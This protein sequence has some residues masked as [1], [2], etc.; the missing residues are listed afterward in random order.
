MTEDGR[1]RTIIENIHP[2]V[3]GGRFC[4]KHVAGRPLRV[5]AHI[6]CDGHDF[7][8]AE[9]S[10]RRSGS[11]HKGSAHT[12]AMEPGD[13]DLFTASFIPEQVGVW[14]FTITAWVDH[15]STMCHAIQ[16]KHAAGVDYSLDA[17]E[18]AEWCTKASAAVRGRSAA[19]GQARTVL[20]EAQG[21]FSACTTNHPSDEADRLVRDSKLK[22]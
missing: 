10:F 18:L 2:L 14:E 13:N 21:V 9:L 19:A 1:A 22:A 4:A 17:Q 5:S 11:G 20:K 12:V 7:V 15:P 16:K 3:D 6:F 8:A